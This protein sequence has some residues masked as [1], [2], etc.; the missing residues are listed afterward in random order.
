MYLHILSVTT[1]Q[2]IM[3]GALARSEK[4]ILFRQE[5]L[6]NRANF[7]FLSLVADAEGNACLNL[8]FSVVQSWVLNMI[9]F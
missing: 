8:S 7:C 3:W 4:E 1:Y 5:S 9:R 6:D 2:I